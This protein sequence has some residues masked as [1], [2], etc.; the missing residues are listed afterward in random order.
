MRRYSGDSRSPRAPPEIEMI[1]DG[2]ATCQYLPMMRATRPGSAAC[3]TRNVLEALLALLHLRQRLLS[4][5]SFCTLLL[6]GQADRS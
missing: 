5:V 4:Q 1:T 2:L 3:D 6:C